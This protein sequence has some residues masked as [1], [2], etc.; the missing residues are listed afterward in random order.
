MK[1]TMLLWCFAATATLWSPAF[2][3]TAGREK[4]VS[5]Q[6]AASVLK[7][8]GLITRMPIGGVWGAQVTRWSI[9]W[10]L[11]KCPVKGVSTRAV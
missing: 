11:G 2:A 9:K 6:V 3:E 10:L 4:I 5:G 7:L 1:R 8:R